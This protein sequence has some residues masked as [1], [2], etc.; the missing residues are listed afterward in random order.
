MGAYE[1]DPD[2]VAYLKGLEQRLAGLEAIKARA[3]AFT[4]PSRAFNTY[5]QPDPKND[6]LL[7]VCIQIDANSAS[8]S[9]AVTLDVNA[10]GTPPDST[11]TTISVANSTDINAV[12][13]IQNLVGI[14]KA[15]YY[16]K[17]TKTGPSAFIS[18]VTEYR[19]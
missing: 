4:A 9:S 19:L 14:V 15:G 6:V 7:I 2:L 10:T 12:S 13:V 1:S 8:G 17:L 5:Y 3:T 16:Y 18:T 11:L